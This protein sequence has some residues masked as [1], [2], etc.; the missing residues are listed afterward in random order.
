MD[1]W[2]NLAG[3]F[4][5]KE[6]QCLVWKSRS[7]PSTMTTISNRKAFP[8]LLQSKP[9]FDLIEEKVMESVVFK[10]NIFLIHLSWFFH[11]LL[12]S[13]PLQSH[14]RRQLA[15][16]FENSLHKDR[17]Y[18]FTEYEFIVHQAIGDEWGGGVW[19]EQTHVATDVS[20]NQMK[21]KIHRTTSEYLCRL[22]NKKKWSA[23]LWWTLLTKWPWD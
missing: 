9:I 7:V 21:L 16:Q 10:Q 18:E 17:D 22:S 23:H 14:N 11:F 4:W 2:S 15:E 19:K 8:E 13:T 6:H 5:G 1:Y 20:L 12:S 3:F